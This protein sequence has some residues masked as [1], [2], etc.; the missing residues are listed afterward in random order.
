MVKDQHIDDLRIIATLAVVTLH[1][2]GICDSFYCQRES[3]EGVIMNCINVCCRFAVPLFV[4]ITGYLLLQPNKVITYK[5][6]ICKYAWRIFVILLSVG[7]F[8]AWLEQLFMKGSFSLMQLAHSLRSVFQGELWDHMWYLYM[9]IGLYLLLP[10]LKASLSSL[11]TRDVDVLL[12]ILLFFTLFV[13]ALQSYGIPQM[14]FDIPIKG[15]FIFYLLLG[16]RLSLLDKKINRNRFTTS[17][18]VL[19]VATITVLVSLHRDVQGWSASH[20]NYKSPLIALLA[21]SVFFTKRECKIQNI[22]SIKFLEIVSKSSFG[23]YIFHPFWMNVLRMALRINPMEYGVFSVL[24]FF[25]AIMILSILTT[26][27]FRKI[28]YLGKYI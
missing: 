21:I 10:L 11:S 1:V 22:S 8:Y 15:P 16:Y 9:L 19:C 26:C 13:P 24:L 23:I 6:A 4:M 25:V 17:L 14:G 7:T 3:V 2:S 28:P 20:L 5:D 12:A 27:V 18:V